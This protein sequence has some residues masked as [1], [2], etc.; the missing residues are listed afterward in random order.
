MSQKLSSRR[1]FL[2]AAAASAAGFALPGVSAA[3][4]A[5]NPLP[6]LPVQQARSDLLEFGYYAIGPED[7]R[8]VI[9]LHD[10][11]YDIHSFADV[12]QLLAAEGYYA[13]APYLRGHGTT[14]FNNTATPRSGEQAAVGS[15]VIALMDVL[16]I[17]EAVIAGFGWGARAACVAAV[18]KPSRCIGIVAV[19]S[20]TVEALDTADPTLPPHARTGLSRQYYYFQTE[21]GRAQL[22][23]TRRNVVRTLWRDNAP[24]WRFNEEAFMRAAEAFDNPDFVDVVVH[25]YRHRLGRASGASQYVAG[26]SK[27]SDRPFVSVPTFRLEGTA[28]GIL[29]ARDTA[30]RFRGPYSHELIPGVGHN[31]PMEAPVAF[32]GA[33]GEL[34]RNGK[35]RT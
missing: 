5:R 20:Y 31:V 28:S 23:S 7:G 30:D 22:E 29:P 9:L 10:F 26:Q 17:P 11:A 6:R 3:M 12:A 32:A 15:D 13:I 8:P 21:R 25:S 1:G 33:I 27:L 24:S 2:L 4:A 16:H 34:V 14:R 18:L 19:N 35:W